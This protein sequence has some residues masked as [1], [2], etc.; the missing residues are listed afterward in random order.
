[1]K[2]NIQTAIVVMMNAP[3]VGSSVLNVAAMVVEFSAMIFQTSIR[4]GMA[5][6]GRL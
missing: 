6:T 5:Q 1:M 4:F 2:K 3:N